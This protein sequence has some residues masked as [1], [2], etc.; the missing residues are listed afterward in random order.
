MAVGTTKEICK[1]NHYNTLYPTSYECMV[2]TTKVF[3]EDHIGVDRNGKQYLYFKPTSKYFCL[4]G[5]F[6]GVECSIK[7]HEENVYVK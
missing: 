4:D 3:T 5:V 6:C 1:P 7:W 2:C